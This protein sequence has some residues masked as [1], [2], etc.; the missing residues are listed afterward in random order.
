[1]N[2]SFSALSQ[3]PE[4]TPMTEGEKAMYQQENDGTTLPAEPNAV[5]EM[6]EELPGDSAVSAGGAEPAIAESAAAEGEEGAA[7]ADGNRATPAADA[8]AEDAPEDEKKSEEEPTAEEGA[9][10]ALMKLAAGKVSDEAVSLGDEVANAA[11]AASAFQALGS[12]L[13][14][15]EE[16]EQ[17]FDDLV[18]TLRES[19]VVPDAARET[20]TAIPQQRPGTA[21]MAPAGVPQVSVPAST[22]ATVGELAGRAIAGAVATPFV[23]LS[24]AARHLANRFHAS[25]VPAAPGGPAQSMAAS[26]GIPLP[27]A[28][29]LETITDWKCERIER[30]GEAVEK[31]ATELMGT[32]EFV[33]WDEDVRRVAAE[34]G[35]APSEVVSRMHSEPELADLKSK[36]DGLWAAHPD[37][38]KAYR[39][40]CDDF[41]RNIRN[42]VKEFPNSEDRI[43]SR[44]TAA[45]KDAE[46]KTET[47]PGFGD[48]MG[49]YMKSLAER[50][51]ELAKAIA[52][53]MQSLVRKLG[54]RTRNGDLTPTA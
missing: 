15:D 19:P 52:E 18:S 44:V 10:D 31:A 43:K 29:T 6:A 12:Q 37:K 39:G 4:E 2:F 20:A 53:F 41:E 51:R 54:G 27:M 25:T 3:T 49:E 47:L 35:V 42:V 28:N 8:T 17:A 40:A 33:T 14:L 13:K 11:P 45:M 21:Q 24:S 36:M 23:A 50:V 16:A 26:R 32:A 7:I 5:S 34:R 22:A 1:M 30:A 46:E 38:V 9:L 48:N